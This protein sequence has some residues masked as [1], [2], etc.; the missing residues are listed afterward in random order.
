MVTMAAPRSM[1]LSPAI[2]NGTDHFPPIDFAY[3]C[4]HEGLRVL[5]VS[6]RGFS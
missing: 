5:S 1:R 4:D 2:I 6:C 3:H